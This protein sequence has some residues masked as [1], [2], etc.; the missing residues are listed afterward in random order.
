[1]PLVDLATEAKERI[2]AILTDAVKKNRTPSLVFGASNAER[3]LCFFTAENRSSD[4]VSSML[5]PD[6]IFWICSQTKMIASIAALQLVEAGCLNLESPVADHIPE[7]ANPVVLENPRPI[8]RNRNPQSTFRAARTTMQVKHLL[9]HS[10]GLGYPLESERVK[11]HHAPTT[12][13]QTYTADNPI[14]QFFRHLKG[15]YPGVPL[16]H[17]PGTSFSYGYSADV[18]GFIISRIS[19]QSLD[20]YCQNH[21]FSPLGITASFYLNQELKSRLV[22]L[23]FREPDGRMVPWTSSEQV[24][25]IERDPE[26]LHIHLAGLGIYCSM[27]DYLKLLRH[28]LQ[29]LAGTA[30]RPLLSVISVQSFFRRSPTMTEAG[31]LV[32]RT[33][34]VPLLRGVGDTWSRALC[35]NTHE[36]EFK[37]EL[38][39]SLVV[40]MPTAGGIPTSGNRR[41]PGSG[42]WYGWAGTYHFVDPQTGVAAVLGTQILPTR[43]SA[44]FD[45]WEQLEEALYRGLR[46][47]AM[48]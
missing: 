12:Y 44:V 11:P 35:V 38:K 39:S 18:L 17:D 14:G 46:I 40:P 1:M 42:W 41:A 37:S 4:N 22:P 33:Q 27:R 5:T 29:I 24:P 48:L 2:Q 20:D 36:L 3:E 34:Y 47:P 7:L 25:L 43:D 26:R 16:K 30:E 23:I 19:G 28:L 10:S 31:E 13:T 8:C 32:L 6:S 45:V 15:N 9:D 21:I